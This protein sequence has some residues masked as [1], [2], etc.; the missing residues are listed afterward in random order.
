MSTS[1]GYFWPVFVFLNKS[2]EVFA[3]GKCCI[4]LTDVKLLKHWKKF[5]INSDLQ[6]NALIMFYSRSNI[7]QYHKIK[8]QRI[9]SLLFWAAYMCVK[10]CWWSP[11]FLPQA[12]FYPLTGLMVSGWVTMNRGN[13]ACG[14]SLKSSV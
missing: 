2:L 12:Y 3:N 11:S 13:A 4:F 1:A 6:R 9:T 10:D 8:L 5:Q 7:K 14:F